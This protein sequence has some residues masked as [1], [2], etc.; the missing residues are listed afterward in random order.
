M[1]LGVTKSADENDGPPLW[2][3]YTVGVLICYSCLS[4]VIIGFLI[5]KL[6]PP[7]P[8][9]RSCPVTPVPVRP[10]N[11]VPPTP[12]VPVRSFSKP[13]PIPKPSPSSNHFAM[14]ELSPKDSPP[15]YLTP[16]ST[17]P[18]PYLLN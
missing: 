15:S 2:M 5:K 13:V 12:V 16:F 14:V 1:F 4:S 18:S 11:A 9:T 10:I 6:T 8:R 7:L 3:K 17:P